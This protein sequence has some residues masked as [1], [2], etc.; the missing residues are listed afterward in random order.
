MYVGDTLVKTHMN[1]IHKQERNLFPKIKHLGSYFGA[2][3]LLTGYT[4]L[5][6]YAMK[7]IWQWDFSFSIQS[8]KYKSL[9]FH[10]FQLIV[11]F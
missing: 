4:G 3:Q 6:G 9:F 8:N 2:N 1:H 10:C 5:I 11:L 7:F